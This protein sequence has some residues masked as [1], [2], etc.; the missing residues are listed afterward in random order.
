MKKSIKITLLVLVIA[1]T[2]SLCSC[3]AFERI[4]LGGDPFSF[5]DIVM[6]QTGVNEYKIE[7]TVDSGKKDVDIYFTEGSRLSDKVSPI[8]VAKTVDGKNARFSFTKELTLGENYYLWVIQ[9]DKQAKVS[10]PAPSM[11]PS[12]TVNDDGSAIFNFNFTYDT[13]WGAFC[14]PNGKAVYKSQSPVF[15]ESA[16]MLCDQIEI[17]DEHGELTAE[18]FDENAYYY[19]VITGKEG[20]MKVIS[21]PVMVFDNIISSVESISAT[22]TNDL[23]L[24]LKVGVDESSIYA[25]MVADRLQL[26]I[27]T[28]AADELYV[29]DS[30]YEDGIAT[31]TFDCSNLIF[32]GLWYDLVLTWDGAVVMDVPKSFNGHSVIQSSTVKKDNYVYNLVDWKPEDA[33]DSA[34]M[35]KVYFEEDTTK[36]ADEILKSYLVTFTTYP[37]PTMQVTVQLKSGVTAPVLAITG[38]D[39]TILASAEGTL[40]DDGS[41]TYS[42]E[43]A[44]AFT[45]AEKW[46]DLRF[47]IGT[48]PYEMLK[49]SCIA[50]AD[51]SKE[52]TDTTGARLYEF[53]EWNGF[54]KMMYSDIVVVE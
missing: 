41:Y 38:G 34:A 39:K 44:D 24:Q 45:E 52:Y 17:T 26:L 32:D 7:F 46:Y 4:F 50:Y 1:M 51:Y 20:L 5:S 48:T 21:R 29:V 49:D 25:P 2:L 12:I 30:K 8:E 37:T 33:D 15:D 40:N 27:K 3:K 19:S 43:V 11:F 18:Q 47:F 53:R 54:L 28:S 16:V 10:I 35:L 9:G 6:T 23:Q 36:Y 14:D 31:M 42:L 22:L 13:A